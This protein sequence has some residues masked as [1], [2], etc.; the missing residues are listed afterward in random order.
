M[1]NRN[2]LAKYFAS[3]GFKIGAEV[4]V[5]DGRY[6]EMLCK[7]IPNLKLLCVDAW[8]AYPDNS[9]D[10]T[11]EQLDRCLR[12]TV[13]RLKAYDV[14]IIKK[15]SLDAVREVRDESLDFVYIDCNHKFDYVM[16][17]I[18]AWGRK[19]KRGGIISGH[20]YWNIKDFGVVSAVDTYVK[21]HGYKL[22]VAGANGR[23]EG[24]RFG[25]SWWFF[26]F[27]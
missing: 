24:R 20:D 9:Q 17:D 1:E 11:Q 18:I 12:I 15:W 23:F 10:G 16:E 19:V 3:L 21:V 8:R 27:A 22:N 25:P 6:S 26:K 14:Q 5:C 13:D 2:E 7:S 4:G